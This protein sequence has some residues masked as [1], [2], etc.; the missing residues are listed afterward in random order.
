MP[1]RSRL[2]GEYGG[3]L[4]TKPTVCSSLSL[5]M[6]AQGSKPSSLGELKLYYFDIPG[7][8]EPI[9]L[10][11]FYAGLELDDYRFG[12]RDEFTKMKESGEL[13]F[14]QV[15]MLRI[16]APESY[17]YLGQSNAVRLFSA[18][19]Q[20]SLRVHR[21]SLGGRGLHP[22]RLQNSPR[23]ARWGMRARADPALHRP[24]GRAV[25][26]ALPRRRAVGG[27]RRRGA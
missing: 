7:K 16:G 19:D 24:T 27:A 21:S 25:G 13:P 1:R 2:R 22:I 11:C 26:R 8:A 20:T 14:G 18:V 5:T 4:R 6:G 10:A 3:S 23:L 12:S 15:P 17:S 9:R